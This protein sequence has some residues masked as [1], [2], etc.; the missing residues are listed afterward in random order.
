MKPRALV[1]LYFCPMFG[2]CLFFVFRVFLF[3]GC[4]CFVFLELHLQHMEVPRL[5]VELALQLLAYTI[6]TATWI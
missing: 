1:F 2:A 5:E 6:A 4:F 3:I